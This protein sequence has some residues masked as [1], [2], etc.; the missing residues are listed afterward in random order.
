[1]IAYLAETGTLNRY[2]GSTGWEG[3]S[4]GRARQRCPVCH[5]TLKEKASVFERKIG[6]QFFYLADDGEAS[7]DGLYAAAINKTDSADTSEPLFQTGL[8]GERSLVPFRG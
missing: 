5:Q 4:G 7:A 6:R 1:M 2:T 8:A 3:R